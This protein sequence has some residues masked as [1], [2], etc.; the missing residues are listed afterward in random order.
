[1]RRLA[2]SR[3]LTCFPHFLRLR[4]ICA[5]VGN[6]SVQFISCSATIANPAEVS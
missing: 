5:A 1:M 4:R 3:M 6:S 2:G